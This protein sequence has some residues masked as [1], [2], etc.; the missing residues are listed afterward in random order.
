MELKEGKY[1]QIDPELIGEEGTNRYWNKHINELVKSGR[2]NWISHGALL[3]SSK[4]YKEGDEHIDR[5]TYG[6]PIKL[7]IS[8]QDLINKYVKELPEFTGF[9]E[10]Y[11]YRYW[12]SDNKSILSYMSEEMKSIIDGKWRKCISVIRF[13]EAEF[14]GH[15]GAW[16][17]FNH[18]Q[19]DNFHEF[20]QEMSPEEYERRY[21][22]KEILEKIKEVATV[23]N[24]HTSSYIGIPGCASVPIPA[25]LKDDSIY[26]KKYKIKRLG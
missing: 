5:L 26:V 1:Y 2:Q 10:G 6:T 23:I 7:Y 15:S 17:W 18:S 19:G 8:Y 22:C 3:I 25:R 16:S 12:R 14:E 13:Q 21:R 24:N 4:C 9:K 11:Y 20:Y